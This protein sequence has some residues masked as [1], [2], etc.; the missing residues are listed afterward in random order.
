MVL[1]KRG[2]KPRLVEREKKRHLE[3]RT[4]GRDRERKERKSIVST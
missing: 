2:M 3:C 4:R 1:R